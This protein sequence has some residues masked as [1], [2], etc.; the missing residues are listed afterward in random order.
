VSRRRVSRR[1]RGKR[2]RRSSPGLVEI[3]VLAIAILAVGAVAIHA[4]G[5]AANLAVL[6]LLLAGG[7]AAWRIRRQRRADAAWDRHQQAQ[8]AAWHRQQQAQVAEWHKQ[9]QARVAAR[10]REHELWQ[11]RTGSLE[12]LDSLSPT[13]FEHAVA[14]LLRR[15]GWTEVQVVGGPDIRAD[16]RARDR[17]GLRVIV[18]AKKYRSQPVG[19]QAV[20]RLIG[21]LGVHQ[22]DRGLLVTNS[23]FTEPALALAAKE[24]VQLIDRW[25]LADMVRAL[26]SPLPPTALPPPSQRRD[27]GADHDSRLPGT[28]RPRQTPTPKAEMPATGGLWDQRHWRACVRCRAR[29]RWRGSSGEPL[30]QN[31]ARFSLN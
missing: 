31:C 1:R 3:A 29:T 16:I 11:A 26:G 10:A 2:G 27:E 8:A 7:Y 15:S 4:V 13:Q 30:C 19:S 6:A 28:A 24:G 21:D 22:A 20:R 25:R 5:G 14:I 12:D 9:Q 23:T 17:D 18:Q